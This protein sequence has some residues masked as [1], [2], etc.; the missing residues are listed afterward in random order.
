[1]ADQENPPVN[2][3]WND[4]QYIRS[5]IGTALRESDH[6]GSGSGNIRTRKPGANMGGIHKESRM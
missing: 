6:H 4:G 3:Q 2:F 1:M 5:E